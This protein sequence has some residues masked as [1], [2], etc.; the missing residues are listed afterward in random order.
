MLESLDADIFG[1]KRYECI[2]L[3]WLLFINVTFNIIVRCLL[4]NNFSSKYDG[5]FF[6]LLSWL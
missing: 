1:P 5:E 2:N 6:L 3:L 4:Q